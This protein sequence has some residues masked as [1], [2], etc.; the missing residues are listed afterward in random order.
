MKKQNLLDVLQEL[1]PF[2]RLARTWLGKRKEWYETHWKQICSEL[3]AFYTGSYHDWLALQNAGTSLLISFCGDDIAMTSE[4]IAKYRRAFNAFFVET[5]IYGNRLSEAEDI[6]GTVYAHLEVFQ[7]INKKYDQMKTYPDERF[8]ERITRLAAA[9]RNVLPEIAPRK[10]DI[11]KALKKQIVTGILNEIPGN[12][13]TGE[14]C[15]LIF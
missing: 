7:A 4:A 8:S 9:I 15:K 1:E 5:K 10:V 12:I 6:S 13:P 11:S 14:V 3:W 2:G